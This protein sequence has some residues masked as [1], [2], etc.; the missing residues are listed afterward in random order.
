MISVNSSFN[1]ESVSKSEDETKAAGAALAA[2]LFLDDG[3]KMIIL[4]GTLGAGKTTFA[5]GFIEGWCRSTG[6]PVPAVITSPTYNIVKTYGH[7]EQLA[8]FDLY[9][10]KDLAELFETGYE[11]YVADS[12][13]TLI[14]WAE[15]VDGIEKTFFKDT[16]IVEIVVQDENSRVIRIRKYR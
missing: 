13:V 1:K 4:S 2:A 3:K 16:L 8:H 7:P 12:K 6:F 5:R 9:R 10:L 15:M 11:Q 14:E